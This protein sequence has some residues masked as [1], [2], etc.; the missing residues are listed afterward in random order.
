MKTGDGVRVR[1]SDVAWL[2]ISLSSLGK[3]K[4]NCINQQIGHGAAFL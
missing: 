4:L 3:V 2:L 1:L